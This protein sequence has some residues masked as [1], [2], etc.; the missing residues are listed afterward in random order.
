MVLI[1]CEEQCNLLN[2]IFV[3]Y[4]KTHLRRY[5]KMKKVL[6]LLFIL[7]M[8]VFAYSAYGHGIGSK[9]W[10]KNTDVISQLGLSSAQISSLNQIYTTDEGQISSFYSQLKSA[11]SSLRSSLADPNSTSDQISSAA[12]TVLQI[13]QQIQ[14][15]RTNMFVALMGVLS[16]QQRSQLQQIFQS[17]FQSHGTAG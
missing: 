7:P 14:G 10:W 6:V 3:K 2:G 5:R 9:Q 1:Y 13:K 16:S 12:N 8:F 11:G 4:I 17:H 15:A